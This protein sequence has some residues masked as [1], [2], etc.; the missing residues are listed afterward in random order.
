M[1]RIGSRIGRPRAGVRTVLSLEAVIDDFD[2]NDPSNERT[3][4]LAER[5]RR[6]QRAEGAAPGVLDEQLYQRVEQTDHGQ[7]GQ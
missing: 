7:R 1:G 3:A 5:L 2:P 6:A 4:R